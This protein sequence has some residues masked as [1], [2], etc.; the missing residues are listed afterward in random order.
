MSITE[1]VRKQDVLGRATD[2]IDR[3]GWT[4]ETF[5]VVLN[6]IAGLEYALNGTRLYVELVVAEALLSRAL[7]VKVKVDDVVNHVSV[8]LSSGEKFQSVTAP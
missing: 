8:Y 6:H 5:G 2:N 3:V 4:R 7:S 1:P